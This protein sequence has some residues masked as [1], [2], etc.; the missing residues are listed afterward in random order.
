MNTIEDTIKIND[1]QDVYLP[2]YGGPFSMGEILPALYQARFAFIITNNNINDLTV[3]FIDNIKTKITQHNVSLVNK[4]KPVCRDYLNNE[5]LDRL[6]LFDDLVTQ[7]VFDNVEGIPT[8]MESFLR[9][10]ILKQETSE[11]ISYTISFVQELK[12]NESSLIEYRVLVQVHQLRSYTSS[13]W[14][15]PPK[16]MFDRNQEIYSRL[17]R[18]V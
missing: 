13:H 5:F 17:F 6:S 16:H 15:A 9:D 2:L 10:S 4:L 18:F 14:S 8:R 1:I 12:H 3:E 7:T 11:Q